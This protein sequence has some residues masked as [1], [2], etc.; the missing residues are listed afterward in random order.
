V[1]VFKLLFIL[2]REMILGKL[3]FKQAFRENKIRLFFFLLVI[4]SFYANYV[5]LPKIY[6]ITEQKVIM[7]RSYKE[8]IET[9]QSQ[10]RECRT[11][12]QSLAS[13]DPNTPDILKWCLQE[14]VNVT[15]K[16]IAHKPTTKDS[17]IHL[18]P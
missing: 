10:L 4:I 14:L 2:I 11:G 3:T 1:S 12:K 17:K 8:Q 9:L 5:T 6:A 13:G 7:E 18:S 16:P 15:D